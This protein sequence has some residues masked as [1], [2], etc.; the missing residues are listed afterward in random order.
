MDPMGMGT[1]Q[2]QPTN[3]TNPLGKS[4]LGEAKPL[5]VLPYEGTQLSTALPT[6][7]E[8]EVAVVGFLGDPGARLDLPGVGPGWTVQVTCDQPKTA[9]ILAT[10]F[11]WTK[12]RGILAK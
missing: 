8:T 6:E 11:W 10:K 5:A 4:N 12:S 3:G 7:T 9:N 1:S 2:K